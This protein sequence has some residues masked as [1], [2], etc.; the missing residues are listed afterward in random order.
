MSNVEFRMAN[1]VEHRCSFAILNSIFAILNSPSVPHPL[2]RK[3]RGT[4]A[5]RQNEQ[6]A[7]CSGRRI[8]PVK[9]GVK[10]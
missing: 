6:P 8:R 7:I 3:G 10:N 4:R 2:L 9:N 1:G 5:R